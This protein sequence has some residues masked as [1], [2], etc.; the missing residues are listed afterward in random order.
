MK[1]IYWNT[2]GVDNIDIQ[3]ALRKFCLVHKPRIDLISEPISIRMHFFL[4]FGVVAIE[5]LCWLMIKVLPLY[6]EL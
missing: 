2:R 6:G 5:N 3:N 1:I 4:I